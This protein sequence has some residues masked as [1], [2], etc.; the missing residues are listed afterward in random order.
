MDL[1][2]ATQGAGKITIFQALVFPGSCC[3]SFFAIRPEILLKN[4][5]FKA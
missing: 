3:C 1:N 4:M 5:F 2:I